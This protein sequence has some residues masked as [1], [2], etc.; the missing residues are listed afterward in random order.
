MRSS[1]VGGGRRLSA[2]RREQAGQDQRAGDGGHLHAHHPAAELID[3]ALDAIARA[4]AD[5]GAG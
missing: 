3:L 2:E 4:A 5:P 1:S